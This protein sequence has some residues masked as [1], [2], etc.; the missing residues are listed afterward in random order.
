MGKLFK[1]LVFL[2]FY[3]LIFMSSPLIADAWEDEIHPQRQDVSNADKSDQN[4]G[5][6]LV[7][8]YRDHIS[9]IDGSQC[10][11]QPSCSSYSI[12]AFKKHGFFIG[13]MLSIDRL[14]HEGS[15]ETKVSPLVFIDGE[16]KILDPVE[17]NDF[18]WFNGNKK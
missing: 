10:P 8:F 3:S 5:S 2:L 9:P 13:W 14:L 1:A 4:M 16:W 7:S 6:L 18:W 15:E 17:N 12:Q 11:S